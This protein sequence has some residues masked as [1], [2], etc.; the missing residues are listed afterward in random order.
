MLQESVK[1]VVENRVDSIVEKLIFISEREGVADIF[2]ANPSR[3]RSE[4]QRI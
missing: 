4:Q 3:E 1:K 2:T